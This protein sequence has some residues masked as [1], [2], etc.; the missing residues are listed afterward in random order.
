[1]K[2]EDEDEKLI[3]EGTFIPHPSALIPFFR[4]PINSDVSTRERLK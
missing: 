1:M 4:C 3:Y 2:D